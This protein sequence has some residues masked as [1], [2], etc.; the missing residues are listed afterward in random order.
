MEG[1]AL[2]WFSNLDNE[3]KEDLDNLLEALF[4]AFSAT[5]PAFQREL[6]REY[7]RLQQCN[8]QSINEYGRDFSLII[9]LMEDPPSL[10]KQLVCFKKGLLP[11]IRNKLEIRDDTDVQDMLLQAKRVE[12]DCITDINDGFNSGLTKGM[13]HR[14]KNHKLMLGIHKTDDN[15]V[16]TVSSKEQNP[17][18]QGVITAIEQMQQAIVQQI[19]AS[20]KPKQ[21]EEPK[22][23]PY[24]GRGQSYP[25]KSLRQQAK[26]ER[27]VE[28][29]NWR[30]Q[31]PNQY[32]HKEDSNQRWRQYHQPQ[33]IA[34]NQLARQ[35]CSFHNST[36]HS[37]EECRSQ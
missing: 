37:N 35:F 8:G 13:L 11:C 1:D 5:G 31:K 22:Q 7:E 20:Q 27:R 21:H 32:Y 2:H 29:V 34:D 25:D 10:P 17:T 19:S 33:A 15:E 12:A 18:M 4:E 6:E 24:T 16:L 28:R 36:M 26:K 14:N 23:F 30:E 3:V 9:G